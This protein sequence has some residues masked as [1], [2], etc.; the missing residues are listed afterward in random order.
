M[1]SV[2]EAK[3]KAVEQARPAR[4]LRLTLAEWLTAFVG[5][6]TL[7]VAGL[8]YL[9]AR[10]TRDLKD[11]VEQL[12]DLAKAETRLANSTAGQ[13]AAMQAEVHQL[14][15]QADAAAVQADA[16]RSSSAILGKQLSVQQATF[17][18]TYRPSV[19][20][21]LARVSDMVTDPHSIGLTPT[22]QIFNT[23]KSAAIATATSV[24]LVAGADLAVAQ[25]R[26]CER[27]DA[28]SNKI[29][30]DIRAGVL[31]PDFG[32]L[33]P[34]QPPG[35]DLARPIGMNT[36]AI[37]AKASFIGRRVFRRYGMVL[38]SWINPMVVGCI[39]FR[40]PLDEAAHHTRFLY[41][42]RERGRDGTPG[43]IGFA[44]HTTKADDVI[45]QPWGEMGNSGD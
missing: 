8:A 44:P 28:A 5:V 16:A 9:D 40:S 35:G 12:R 1:N 6:G 20:V 25:R 31:A 43:F 13:L 22:F 19:K 15:R 17:A 2:S 38:P 10:N 36:D 27:A 21:Q 7:A 3:A 42:L 39:S 14:S 29:R 34:D 24:E 30:A 33:Q 11:A 37:R 41:W 4:F 26:V 18:E 23:G 32:W 45:L